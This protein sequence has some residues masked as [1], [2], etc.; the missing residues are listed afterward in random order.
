MK[1]RT[2]GVDACGV[3]LADYEFE[4]A[5]DEEAE[6][7]ASRY[8][9]VHPVIEVWQGMRRV[10]RLTRNSGQAGETDLQRICR[11][12]QKQLSNVFVEPRPKGK[13]EGSPIEDFVVEDHVDHVLKSFR[14]QDEAVR[15]AK[16]T[17][18]T[19]HIARVR[20]LNDK[21]KPDQWREA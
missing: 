5:T 1:Y 2:H 20:H 13:P 11:E 19:P 10:A 7:R 4:C 21:K 16:A 3:S 17:G 12:A 18:H 15:W 8:L 6:E 14:T 9:N